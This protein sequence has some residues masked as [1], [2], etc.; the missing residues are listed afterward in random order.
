MKKKFA[1]PVI[2]WVLRH[3]RKKERMKRNR[4]RDWIQYN[5]ARR[6]CQTRAI[7]DDHKFQH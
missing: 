7:S 4:D 2:K 6:R 5:P 3:P 1:M